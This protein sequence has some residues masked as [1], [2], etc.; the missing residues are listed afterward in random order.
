VY[1]ERWARLEP[2]YYSP[3][4]HVSAGVGLRAQASRR[5]WAL[6]GTVAPQIIA[7]DGTGGFGLFSSASIRRK[8]GLVW[9]GGEAAIFDDRRSSYRLRRF[10]AEVRIPFGR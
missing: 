6:D 1:L 10:A 9:L 8:V 5:S 2:A 7:S 4:R 3:D